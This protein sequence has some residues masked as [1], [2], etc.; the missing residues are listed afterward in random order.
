MSAI[1]L[2]FPNAAD[3]ATLSSS[4]AAVGAMP[5]TY[6]QDQ[7]RA[8]IWRSDSVVEAQHILG[9]LAS[10]AT[11]SAVALVRHNLTTSASYR[12]RLYSGTGQTGTL[13]Y[14]SGTQSVGELVLG[15]GDFA[16][17][18]GTWGAESAADWP[19]SYFA[20]FFAEVQALSFDLQID[21]AG[22]P[23]GYLQAARLVLGQSW[24][25]AAGGAAPGLSLSWRETS[26]QVRTDGGTLRTDARDPYRRIAFDLNALDDDERS[27][28]M[29]KLRRAGRRSDI[30]L[31]A[32]AGEGGA[33]ERDYTAL[34]KLVESPDMIQPF[35]RR[36]RTSLVFEES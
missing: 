34:V 27:A 32:H 22:N 6:L 30:F 16:W 1:R 2:V 5:V 10:Y 33:T 9:D 3:A 8:R 31:S 14:D 35:F 18:V 25:P 11:L 13:V 28:L 21:D 36:F 17:G 23:D 4:P 24:S 7:T 15:W 19:V 29:D 20:H 26:R 12:L